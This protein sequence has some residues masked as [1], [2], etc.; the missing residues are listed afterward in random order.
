MEKGKKPLKTLLARIFFLPALTGFVLLLGFN[1]I[2]AVLALVFFS[3]GVL[4][5]PLGLLYMLGVVRVVS[6]LHPAALAFIGAFCF[7]FGVVLGFS[8]FRFAP[9]SVRLIYKYAALLTDKSYRRIYS[10]FTIASYV[11]FSVLLSAIFLCAGIGVQILAVKGGF[12]STVIKDSVSFDVCSFVNISTSD[13]DFELKYYDGSKILA[14][15]VNDRPIIVENSDVNYLKLTQDDSFTLSLFAREQFNYKLTIWL[16]KNDYREFYL[17]SGSGD[18]QLDETLALYTKIRTRSGNIKI[19]D[20]YE[21]IDAATLE[22]NI[23][24]S[25]IAF[26]NTGSFENRKGKILLLVPDFSGVN[27]IFRTDEGW[28]DSGLMGLSERFYGSMDL[29]KAGTLSPDLYVTTKTGNL[30]LE[31][32]NAA[33]DIKEKK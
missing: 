1:F 20:A 9:F 17:N 18:I 15:Y 25:Y 16:P 8:V 21:R 4:C 14:E 27:L 28:L 26:A 13:L 2:L 30:T 29:K 24:C 22:G 5:T 10:N 11:K 7:F 12:K 31:A 19:A 33:S 32:S 6:D 3:A 23:S